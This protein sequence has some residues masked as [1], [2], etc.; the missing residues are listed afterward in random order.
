MVVERPQAVYVS[1]TAQQSTHLGVSVLEEH[2]SY[3]AVHQ[4]HRGH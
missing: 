4:R 1:P 2:S 3:P